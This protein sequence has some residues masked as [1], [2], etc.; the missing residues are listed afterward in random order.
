MTMVCLHDS[1]SNEDDVAN[2]ALFLFFFQ[3]AVRRVPW[4]ARSLFAQTSM[5]LQ[6]ES[7]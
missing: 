5:Q 1:L 2:V 7:R 6:R 4:R 3:D